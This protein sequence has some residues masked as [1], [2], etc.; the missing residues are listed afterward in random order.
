MEKLGL[1]NSSPGVGGFDGL[2][3]AGGANE[4]IGRVDGTKIGCAEKEETPTETTGGRTFF[5]IQ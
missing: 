2:R 5:N 4:Q 3:G 1:V